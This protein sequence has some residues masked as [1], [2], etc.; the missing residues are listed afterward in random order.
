[1]SKWHKPITKTNYKKNERGELTYSEQWKKKMDELLCIS[2][3]ANTTD[4]VMTHH[5]FPFGSRLSESQLQFL[6]PKQATPLMI[7]PP[8]A[9]QI[10]DL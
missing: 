3:V 10:L 2:M 1:M 5:N 6:Y 8:F 4:G 9:L 7:I